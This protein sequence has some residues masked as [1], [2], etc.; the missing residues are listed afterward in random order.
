MRFTPNDILS[1]ERRETDAV[2]VLSLCDGMSCGQ[3]AL[4]ELNMPVD[5][6]YAS[7]IKK[8][9]IQVTQK[10]FP[11][12]VQIGNVMDY[13]IAVTA[14][15]EYIVDKEKLDEL[16]KIDLFLCGSPCKNMSL[17]N[18]TGKSGINGEKSSLFYPCA[19]I[20]KY[21]KP[22]YFLF[23]NV[24]S[25][26]NADKAV[27]NTLLGVMPI[28]INSA[29]VSAQERNRYYWT[30]IPNVTIPNDRKIKLSDI[31]D[32]GSDREENWSHKKTEFVERKI[33]STMYVR[34]DG[35]KSLPITARGYAAWNTQ[36]VTDNGQYRDLT[37][38]EY[39]R[40]QTIPDW[41]DF[42]GLAKS[43][44]TD[45]IGDGW[46]IEVIVHILKELK[47]RFH[48]NERQTAN[49]TIPLISQNADFHRE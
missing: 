30:N 43:K 29:L 47:N 4:R 9:A 21:V 7:E 40:L 18:I 3:I 27:F 5:V 17:M 38:N 11:D 41:Y 32:Y 24:C 12:T 23:E 33:K 2:N 34:V 49:G 28:H 44:I 25:M 36:F 48:S 13:I 20:M 8:H 16:G 39:R 45:L 14:K 15:G 31:I 10:N 37:I 6:Y 19:A 46:T 22:T 26:T 1:E 35:E 42:D